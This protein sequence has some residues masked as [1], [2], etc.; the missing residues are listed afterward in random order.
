MVVMLVVL[1]LLSWGRQVVESVKAAG[2]GGGGRIVAEGG[3]IRVCARGWGGYCLSLVCVILKG[4][5]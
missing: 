4:G 3:V 1:I 5:D 2:W